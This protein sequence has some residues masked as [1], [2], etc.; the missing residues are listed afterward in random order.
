MRA[1]VMSRIGVARTRTRKN[2]RRKQKTIYAAPATKI[3]PITTPS[4][5]AKVQRAM[6]FSRRFVSE[7]MRLACDKP[8]NAPE[9]GLKRIKEASR[10]RK[11]KLRLVRNNEI[12]KNTP[13]IKI[14]TRRFQTSLTVKMNGSIKLAMKP[15]NESASPI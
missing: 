8:T 2:I 6:L 10:K 1:H 12:V 14:T 5:P 7:S 13:P 15:G 11:E 9:A 4:D 3:G